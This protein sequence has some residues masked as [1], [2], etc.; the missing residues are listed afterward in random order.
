MCSTCLPGATYQDQLMLVS[1]NNKLVI[2]MEREEK[3]S[4]PIFLAYL[5]DLHQIM[6]N[7]INICHHFPLDQTSLSL[8][9]MN[10]STLKTMFGNILSSDG[11]AKHNI[12]NTEDCTNFFNCLVSI[13][14]FPVTILY[15]LSEVL[16]YFICAATN[17]FSLFDKLKY[18]LHQKASNLHF[19]LY[20]IYHLCI[21]SKNHICK[22]FQDFFIELLKNNSLSIHLFSNDINTQILTLRIYRKVSSI[23]EHEIVKKAILKNITEFANFSKRLKSDVVCRQFWNLLGE[24]LPFYGLYQGNSALPI[25]ASKVILQEFQL[26]NAKDVLYQEFGGGAVKD[27]HCSAGIINLLLNCAAWSSKSTDLNISNIVALNNLH[28]LPQLIIQNDTIDGRLTTSTIISLFMEDDEHLVDFLLLEFE[29]YCNYREIISPSAMKRSFIINP[30]NLLIEVMF[31][32][33]FDSSVLLDWLMSA[34]TKFLRYLVLC[35]KFLRS[36]W[37]DFT[38]ICALKDEEMPVSNSENITVEK[39]VSSLIK[40]RNSISNLHKSKLFPY[41]PEPLLKHLDAIEDLFESHF[42]V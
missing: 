28:R 4:E 6:K 1:L 13:K 2:D 21:L 37:T 8:L 23:E 17:S 11:R 14:E 10:I 38:S 5:E 32:L 24:M 16:S 7:L 41:A 34:E 29:L 15:S 22:Q 12:F 42:S 39:V 20:V 9:L 30:S 19:L 3:V 35:L 40:L 26:T 33:S 31:S 25:T 36:S 27:A 18:A